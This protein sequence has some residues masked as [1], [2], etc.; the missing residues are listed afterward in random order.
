MIIVEIWESNRARSG[1]KCNQRF[2]WLYPLV[3]PFCLT[4]DLLC[5][6]EKRP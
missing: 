5:W 6:L 4:W 3:L 2:F 1:G